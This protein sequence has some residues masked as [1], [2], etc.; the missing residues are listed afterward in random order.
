MKTKVKKPKEKTQSLWIGAHDSLKR[1]YEERVAHRMTQAEFGR[2]YNIGSQ[3]MV[4]QYLNGDRPLNVEATARFAKGLGCKIR[5]IC[6]AMAEW[7][8]REILPGLGAF[9]AALPFFDALRACVLCQ[10]SGENA[11]PAGSKPSLLT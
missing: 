11:Y 5:D 1:L 9:F 10:M 6:P 2:R 7:L 8:K 4:A 3:S